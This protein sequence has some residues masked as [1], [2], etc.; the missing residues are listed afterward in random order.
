VPVPTLGPAVDL[1]LAHLTPL[2]HVHQTPPLDLVTTT[3]VIDL[4]EGTTTIGLDNHHH[5]RIP[6]VE[7]FLTY[8]FGAIIRTTKVSA[9]VF[10]HSTRASSF[11]DWSG[12]IPPSRFALLIAWG[13][14]YA[15]SWIH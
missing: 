10:A 9:R 4:G 3:V 6:L 1:V 7:V 15:K 5:H 13:I 8:R 14:L 12:N 2:L 11:T